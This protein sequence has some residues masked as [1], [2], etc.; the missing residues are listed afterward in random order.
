M[1]QLFQK[2]ENLTLYMGFLCFNDLEKLLQTTAKDGRRAGRATFP[3]LFKKKATAISIYS[4]LTGKEIPLQ[5]IF[6]LIKIE[7]AASSAL[8]W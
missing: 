7:K 2:K 4:K 5:P 1:V 3:F 6:F 8:G